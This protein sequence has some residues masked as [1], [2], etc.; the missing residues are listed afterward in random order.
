MENSPS[1]K[2]RNAFGIAFA[3]ASVVNG[4]IVVIKESSPAVQAEMKQLTGHHWITHSSIVVL[5]FL[6]LGGLLSRANGGQG[7]KLTINALISTVVG[8]LALG[9]LIIVGYY[10]IGD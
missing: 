3:V 2:Y 4:I 10:L 5:L 6:V 9:A 7:P 1:S 8:G